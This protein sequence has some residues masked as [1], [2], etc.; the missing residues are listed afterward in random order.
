MIKITILSEGWLTKVVLDVFEEEPLP[1]TSKLWQHPKVLISPHSAC[2]DV[3]I[4]NEVRTWDITIL[5]I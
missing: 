5:T 4:Y 2:L 1:A 3:T